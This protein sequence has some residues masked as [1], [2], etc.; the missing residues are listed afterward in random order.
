MPILCHPKGCSSPVCP[1]T[2]SALT[3]MKENKADLAILKDGS[4]K[5]H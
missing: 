3:E 5:I 4:T 2:L 1:F